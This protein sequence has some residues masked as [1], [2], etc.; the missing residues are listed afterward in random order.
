[1][2]NEPGK[3]DEATSG[4]ISLESIRLL[5]QPESRYRMSWNSYPAGATFSG[6]SRAGRRYVIS[7]RCVIGLAGRS[8]ELSGGE[9]LDLPE[10]NYQ[11]SVSGGSPVE[12]IS[13]RELP[14]S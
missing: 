10:G 12:L 1:M 4:R 11:L 3:W 7:G 2:V 5:F 6:W 9:F 14:E 13:V 8:W